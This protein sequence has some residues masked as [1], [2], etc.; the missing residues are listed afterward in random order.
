MGDLAGLQYLKALDAKWLASEPQV[1][2]LE[3]SLKDLK[4]IQVQ[5]Q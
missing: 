4:Q 1:Q 3:E 5:G 2:E